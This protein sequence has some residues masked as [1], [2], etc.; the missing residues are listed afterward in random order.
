MVRQ[1]SAAGLQ[2]RES[3]RFLSLA[4]QARL[5]RAE[6]HREAKGCRGQALSF[7]IQAGLAQV[8]RDRKAKGKT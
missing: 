8:E 2:G 3:C 6:A 5:P 7:A 4:G 1:A